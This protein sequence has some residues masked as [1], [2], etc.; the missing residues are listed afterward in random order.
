[1]P[2]SSTRP[3]ERLPAPT[4]RQILGASPSSPS[5]SGTVTPRVKGRKKAVAL[6]A[7]IIFLRDKS[8]FMSCIYSSLCCAYKLLRRLLVLASGHHNL[9]RYETAA[10]WSQHL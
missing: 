3:A 6:T 9:K 8:A 1:M 10:N 2:A 4:S 7:V 5:T